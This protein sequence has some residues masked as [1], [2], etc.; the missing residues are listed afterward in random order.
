MKTP[1]PQSLVTLKQKSKRTNFFRTLTITIF[2]TTASLLGRVTTLQSFLQPD[3]LSARALFHTT[4]TYTPIKPRVPL[5]METL[6][7]FPGP[8]WHPS[9]RR[10]RFPTVDKRIRLYMS[11][12]FQPP[13]SKKS[14]IAYTIQYD[15]NSFPTLKCKKAGNGHHVYESIVQP[16]VKLLLD[17]ETI[18]DCG[19]TL[20]QWKKE[21][22]RKRTDKRIHKRSNMWNYCFNAIEILNI[23]HKLNANNGRTNTFT[24]VILQMGDEKS[25][26]N[27]SVPYIA[28]FRPRL[29]QEEVER[30]TKKTTCDDRQQATTVVGN[31]PELHGFVPIVWNLNTARHFGYIAKARS[32][33]IPWKDKKLGTLWRG[34]MT[35]FM[36]VGP[37]ITEL[38]QC[39]SNARCRFVYETNLQ[40]DSS[41]ID[42]ALIGVYPSYKGGITCNGITLVAANRSSLQEL[43]QYKVVVALEGNDVSSALKWNLMS[44]SVILMPPPTRTSWAM[45]ELLEPWVHYV[46]IHTNLSNLEEMIRWVGNNDDFAR[47]ISERA[48]LYIYD[49]WISP[50]AKKDDIKVKRGILDRYR[51]YW[52]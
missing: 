37:E 30:V 2:I 18:L 51:K 31:G 20:L 35:G 17:N 15:T 50:E 47:R 45:E 32:E 5:T 38:E 41:L 42:A 24:P 27:S 1:S 7:R 16:D 33:D 52:L 21:G 46:P 9:K 22:A 10:N 4:T 39:L 48:T 34:F 3:F 28:K 25:L 12:W 43:Q 6:T 26:T 11:N 14:K 19:R 44:N 13:C 40:G 8:D 36:E 23:T 29:S 49:L